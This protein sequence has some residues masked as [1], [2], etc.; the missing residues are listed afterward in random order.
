MQQYAA[1]VAVSD[2]APNDHQGIRAPIHRGAATG[3]I[4]QMK[5]TGAAL[6]NLQC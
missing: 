1:M 5:A 3:K 2:C 4:S 6:V